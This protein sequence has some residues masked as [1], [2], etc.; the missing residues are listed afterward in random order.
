VNQLPDALPMQ[1]SISSLVVLLFIS[2]ANHG[3]LT[4]ITELPK[5]KKENSGL[6]SY[7]KNTVW[8]IEDSGNGDYIYKIDFE[9]KI[10]KEFKVKNAKNRDW[11]DLAKDS[12]GNLY[13]GDFGNNGNRRKDLIIYKLPNPE[14]EPGDKIDAEKIE[15]HYPEQKD[16]PPKK[17]K[18]T[19]DAEAFF[20]Y[21]DQLYIFTKNRTDPFTG[22]TWIYKV[23]DKKGE[24]NAKLMGKLKI[25]SDWKTCQVTAADISKDKKTIVLL[26]YGKLWILTNFSEDDFINADI[27]EIDL[28]VRT[29]LESVCFID[30]NTLLL[31]DEETGPEGRNL[32][33]YKLP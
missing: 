2:C 25:C 9:G 26:G 4:Y 11:E 5:G 10:L 16:F 28:G 33:S 7:E 3:Q 21:D 17:K 32:Y 1:K 29:Q 15:F 19:F 18:R 6:T 20:H 27:R 24:Y 31:S 14:T 12:K 23:P 8:G 13:I 22:E 30:K